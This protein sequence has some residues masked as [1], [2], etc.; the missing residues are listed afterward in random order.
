MRGSGTEVLV[1][2]Q[3]A[4]A[5]MIKSVSEGRCISLEVGFG[6]AIFQT[7]GPPDTAQQNCRP[8]WTDVE[9]NRY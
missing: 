8:D 4:E 3:T 1:S 2:S 6:P 7:S 5:T 9:S